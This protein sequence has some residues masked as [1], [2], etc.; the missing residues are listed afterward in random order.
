MK[1]L[2]YIKITFWVSLGQLSIFLIDAVN[3]FLKKSIHNTFQICGDK[4]QRQKN[5][6]NIVKFV[7]YRMKW[8]VLPYSKSY[9]EETKIHFGKILPIFLYSKI[10]LNEYHSKTCMNRSCNE[11][12]VLWTLTSV[13]RLPLYQTYIVQMTVLLIYISLIQR[14]VLLYLIVDQIGSL[15]LSCQWKVG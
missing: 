7:D 9:F 3:S 4:T 6:L 5:S 2:K 10:L 1:L 12:H 14:K 13:D 11:Y 15:F 8:I